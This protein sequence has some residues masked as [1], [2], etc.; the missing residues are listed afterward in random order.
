MIDIPSRALF[1]QFSQLGSSRRGVLLQVLLLTRC[2]SI[3]AL[4]LLGAIVAERV[5]RV[6]LG[7]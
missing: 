1:S 6:V 4:S 2:A 3:A 7:R 5:E